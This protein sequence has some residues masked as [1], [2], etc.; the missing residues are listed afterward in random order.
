M[1][2]TGAF[3]ATLVSA[4]GVGVWLTR[5]REAPLTLADFYRSAVQARRIQASD[6]Q[7]QIV[8]A[9][10]RLVVAFQR[11]ERGRRLPWSLWLSAPRGIYLYGPA[12]RGKSFLLDGMFHTLQTP[13]R[14]RFHFHEL[15]RKVMTELHA[16]QGSRR[17]ARRVA[18]R[19]APAGS[20]VVIDEVQLTDL[21]SATVFHALLEAWWRRRCVVCMSSNDAPA[22][23]VD[24]LPDPERLLRRFERH[25]NAIPMPGSGDYRLGKL[26]GADLYQMPVG[27]ATDKR[28]GAIVA[29]LAESEP[30][31][32]PVTVRGR[33]LPVR[34]RAAG[35]IWFDFADLCEAPNGFGDFLELVDAYANL[36]VSGVP[37]FRELESAR[38]FGWLVELVYDKRRRLLVSAAVPPGELFSA[39]PEAA[40]ESLDFVKISSRLAEMQSTEY[41]YTLGVA[42]DGRV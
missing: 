15:M 37:R 10:D 14:R 20:L 9:L 36:V 4:G 21:G 8:E 5:R 19:L 29:T 12:G 33:Q 18:A 24:G 34:S 7:W 40:G 25:T 1:T 30:V 3:F 39:L 13:A 22:Q 16:A 23:L 11:F 26:T 35:V 28:L 42:I 38:R 6:E 41:N 32:T 2:V 17:A 27:P 31:Q